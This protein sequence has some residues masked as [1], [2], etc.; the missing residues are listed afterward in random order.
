MS[1]S[2]RCPM[3]RLSRIRF[4]VP[5]LLLLASATVSAQQTSPSNTRKLQHQTELWRLIEPHLP[6]RATSSPGTLSTEGDVLRARKFPEDAL[7]F[8]RAALDR[9]GD[10]TP[11]LLRMG[12]T[13]LE[14]NQPGLA[15]AYFKRVT[16]I[17]PKDPQAWNNLG[18]T[19]YLGKNYRGAVSDYRRAVKL[20]K[21][22]ATYHSNLGTAYFE[23]KDFT[24]ARKQ[25]DEALRLDPG[26]F[27]RESGSGVMAHILSPE[28]RARF[29]FEMA[30][31]ALHRNGVEEMLYWLAKAGETGFDIRAGIA[32][33]AT[34]SRYR[35]DV[36]VLTLIH[37]S[38]TLRGHQ[39]AST[40]GTAPALPPESMKP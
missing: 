37:N 2:V 11:L 6:D 15:R 32:E 19:E 30:K 33:D 13:E 18:A 40:A 4:A 3:P 14:L 23:Q 39:L 7:E 20:N 12:V 16:Q 5:C 1:L 31:I 21:Q 26:L 25:F 8:Y 36:R 34:L 38:E 27:Q 24:G 10:P 22:T 29:C 35:A 17:N 9:G 28:D